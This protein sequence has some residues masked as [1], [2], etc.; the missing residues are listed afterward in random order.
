MIT[1]TTQL[2]A[3]NTL[4]QAIGE[5]PTSSL[6]GEIGVDVVTALSTLSSISRAVQMEGWIFNTEYNYPLQR[7]AGGEIYVPAN[8]LVVDIPRRSYAGIDPVLRGSKLYD[9]ANHTGVFTIDVTARL[10][11]GLDFEEMP[12]SARHYVTYRAARKFQDD[13]LGSTDLHRFNE[14]DELM[15]HV[16]FADE[17]A[18][19]EDLNFLTDTPDFYQL[20]S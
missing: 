9:R 1:P 10:V 17:Q 7:D 20:W 8:A 14:K 11:F 12:E 19:D 3:V 13:S 15:A 4:L 18:A 2:D 5:S 6:S 16:R